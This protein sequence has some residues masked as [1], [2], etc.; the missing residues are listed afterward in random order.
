MFSGN[1][2]SLIKRWS[3]GKVVFRRSAVENEGCVQYLIGTAW[4]LCE[5]Q[6]RPCG[7]LLWRNQVQESLFLK[8]SMCPYVDISLIENWQC[9]RLEHISQNIR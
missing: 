8:N 5:S 4:S 7:F 3:G 6:Q 1:D 9:G 2:L